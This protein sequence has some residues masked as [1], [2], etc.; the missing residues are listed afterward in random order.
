MKKM[1]LFYLLLGLPL[2]GNT[3]NVASGV[4]EYYPAPGQHINIENIGTPQ[5]A[6]QMPVEEKNLVLTRWFWWVCCVKI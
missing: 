2:L 1:K 6:Q 5:A 4:L 3:Q